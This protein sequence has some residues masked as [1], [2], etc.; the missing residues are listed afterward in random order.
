MSR[1]V[2]LWSGTYKPRNIQI[3][4][5][6]LTLWLSYRQNTDLYNW[7]LLILRLLLLQLLLVLLHIS[8]ANQVIANFRT[9]FQNIVAMA[10]TVRRG[11]IRLTPFNSP[12]PKT[13]RKHLKDIS[14]TIR[15]IANFNSHFVT[16]TRR[17]IVYFVSIY[18]AMSTR[19]GRW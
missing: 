7:Q 1:P 19:V 3:Y 16:M 2:F 9:N 13:T 12:T 5:N 14:Y 4:V 10:T 8:Y 18:V 6:V 17:V 11:R 15:V